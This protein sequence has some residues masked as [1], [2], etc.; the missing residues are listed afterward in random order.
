MIERTRQDDAGVGLQ[1]VDQPAHRFGVGDLR[2][3]RRVAAHA[4]GMARGAGGVDHVGGLRHG[5]AVIAREVL[6]PVSRS[7]WRSPG[8]AEMLAIDLVACENLRRR[9]HR[10]HGDAVGNGLAQAMQ[11][12]GMRDQHARAGILQHVVDLFRL[13]VPVDR[14][15]IGPE[16]H[17]R[18]GQL[19][20]GDVVAHQHAD[21]VAGCDA[22]RMQ[23][24]GDA[25][26][27]A[28]D[29][30][31]AAAAVAAD[32][33]VEER[34]CWSLSVA[35]SGVGFSRHS[36]TVRRT[37]PGISRFRV[38]LFEPPRNDSVSWPPQ[39]SARAFPCW[40]GRLR[41]GWGCR[42]VSAARPTPPASAGPGSTERLFIMR[43]L[44]RMACGFLAAISRAISMRCRARVVDDAGRQA[45]AQRF[46]RREDAAGV[47]ELAQ[48]IVA[49]EA[50]QDRRARHV[51]HQAPFDL[52]DRHPRI[53]RQQADVGAER[54][55]EA[56][57]E[58][59]ALDGGD[60]RHR[61][62]PPAPHRLLRE[63]GEAVGALAEIAAFAARLLRY[64]PS[65]SWRRN[66]PCR[67]RRRRRGP[68]RT[69]L[70]PGPLSPLKAARSPP[71]A[72]RTWPGPAHSS[73]P[74]APDGR[75]R[76]RQRSI[77]R[78]DL[79]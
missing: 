11:H 7:R 4:L 61:E 69:I 77:S 31:M 18:I 8:V 43:L 78:R 34:G 9:R 1:A 2:R 53:R 68:R 75:R 38:R 29:F 62:L 22:E 5:G 10:E 40:R 41:S 67:G 20:E 30:V 66:G 42:A 64:R 56:A 39:T 27:A 72:P 25:V 16:P 65:P 57:A 26:G 70:P 51:R 76:Y 32:D 6:Q 73:C 37:G 58:G 12:V 28:G 50:R 3:R 63:I 14:H 36:G 48:N 45:I 54:E 79:P 71:P 17:R 60:H 13:E 23:A 33:A 52:H 46:L 35:D 47:G 24:G 44:A 15:A 74:R 55:L 49:H 59:D 21:A 19:D